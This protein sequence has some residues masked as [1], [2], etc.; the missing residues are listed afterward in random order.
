M[1][2]KSF[3][4]ARESHQTEGAMYRVGENF[5]QLYRDKGLTTR[6]Y[7]ELKNL[8]FQ[9]INNPLSKWTNVSKGEVQTASKHSKKG[10]ARNAQHLWL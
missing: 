7:R 5:C 10:S 4:T 1:E 9:R 3:F 8:N 2:L 6:I